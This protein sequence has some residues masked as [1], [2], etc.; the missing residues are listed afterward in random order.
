MA[1]RHLFFKNLGVG[2]VTAEQMLREQGLKHL[3]RLDVQNCP[4]ESRWQDLP[5][6]L[7]SLALGIPL[8]EG[9]P[10]AI[11]QL[12][13]LKMLVL[14]HV[15][16]GLM[17]LTR[18]LYPFLDMKSLVTLILQKPGLGGVDSDINWWTPA[19]LGLLGLADRRVLRMK[20]APG[21]KSL[22][23]TY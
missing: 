14:T 20:N 21:G 9:I 7:E 15:G 23:F 16:E 22:T 6:S 18:P 8:N 10:Q 2:S 17:H 3:F 4:G 12:T 19:A 13:R 5:H 1:S 11:E